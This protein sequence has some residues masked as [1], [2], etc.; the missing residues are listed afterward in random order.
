MDAFWDVDL[1]ARYHITDS[2]DLF[3]SVRNVLDSK[4]PL[5]VIDY[6]G[7]NYNPTFAQEGIVGRFFSIGV[8]VRTDSL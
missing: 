3:G 8:A 1:T 7:V 2:M 6:A 4:P 5:D